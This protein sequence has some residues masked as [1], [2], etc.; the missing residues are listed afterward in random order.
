MHFSGRRTFTILT[1]FWSGDLA[2][3]RTLS[4]FKWS[5]Y[6]EASCSDLSQALSQAGIA[7]NKLEETRLVTTVTIRTLQYQLGMYRF[8]RSPDGYFF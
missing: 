8:R 7:C 4:K 6:Q 3:Q 5:P 1:L 2:V